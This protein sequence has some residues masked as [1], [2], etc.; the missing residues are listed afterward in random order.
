MLARIPRK[1]KSPHYLK[2]VLP[3]VP[4]ETTT[5]E[6][7]K[8]TFILMELKAKAGA[9]GTNALTY[10]KHF[11][12]FEEGSPEEWIVVLK[13]L[14]EIWKQNAINTATDKA[15]TVRSLLK[16]ESLTAFEAALTE[17]RENEDGE[18]APINE[19][20]LNQ[21]LDAVTAEV[22]PH[23]ALEIQ[24]M[25]MQRGMK[26]PYKMPMRKTAAAITKLNNDLVRFPGATAESKFSEVELIG[27]IE[28]S[29]PATWRAKF[30]LEG[31]IPTQDTKK[32]LIEAGEAIER[33]EEGQNEGKEKNKK[34]M[35][36]IRKR[37]KLTL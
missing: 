9:T 25:W 30:D 37:E 4:E 5:L 19:N 33:N 3:L 35:A 28:W 36:K 29:L 31:Y 23:R 32:R 1:N 20:H 10:K 22:F 16:G 6:E 27:L 24:K 8:G 12:L 2:P 18:E 14:E 17:A 13:N 7:K 21:A 34:K 15:A 26:K 11:K